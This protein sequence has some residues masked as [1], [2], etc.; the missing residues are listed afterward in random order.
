MLLGSPSYGW[1]AG[2][3]KCPTGVLL[4]GGGMLNPA[5]LSGTD[6]S[7]NGICAPIGDR[8]A[9]RDKSFNENI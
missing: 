3:D 7:Q 5:V 8:P 1:A 9:Q 4:D 6:T 2:W